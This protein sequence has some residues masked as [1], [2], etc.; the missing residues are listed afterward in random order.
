MYFWKFYYLRFSLDRVSLHSQYLPLTFV[1]KLFFIINLFI[2]S[3]LL[4]EQ[5]HAHSF[6]HPLGLLLQDNGDLSTC[7]TDYLV[8]QKS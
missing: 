1:S 3:K 4:L 5:S 7:N 8:L 6:T 2:V